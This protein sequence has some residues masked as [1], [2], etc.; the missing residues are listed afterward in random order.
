MKLRGTPELLLVPGVSACSFGTHLCYRC[1]S[2]CLSSSHSSSSSRLNSAVAS[3]GCLIYSG[4]DVQEDAWV[5]NASWDQIFPQPQQQTSR[6]PPWLTCLIKA[7]LFISQRRLRPDLSLYERD[8][9]LF[10]HPINFLCS[11]VLSPPCS[12]TRPLSLCLPAGAAGSFS[13]S[14]RLL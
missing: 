12:P 10:F 3:D 1:L 13:D 14:V 9:F 4:Q 8:R 11:A 2:S 6:V 5:S 7:L